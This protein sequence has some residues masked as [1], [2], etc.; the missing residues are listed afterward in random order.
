[1]STSSVDETKNEKYQ[2]LVYALHEKQ[3]VIDPFRDSRATRG[4]D[5]NDGT[6]HLLPPPRDGHYGIPSL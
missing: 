4:V 5:S 6:G 2:L 3:R 1:M